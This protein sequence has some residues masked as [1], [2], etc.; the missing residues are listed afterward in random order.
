MVVNRFVRHWVLHPG[1]PWLDSLF[2]VSSWILALTNTFQRLRSSVS[3]RWCLSRNLL[4]PV[5]YSNI[6]PIHFPISLD[7]ANEKAQIHSCKQ[8]V[9]SFVSYDKLFF[10]EHL[11][12][13]TWGLT[14]SQGW[15]LLKIKITHMK[16]VDINIGANCICLFSPNT[17]GTKPCSEIIIAS[18]RSLF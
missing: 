14:D 8:K 6:F 2:K 7:D 3:G 4:Y 5:F 15:A 16:I 10:I 13:Y 17:T 1:N 9:K 12:K 11:E 18:C